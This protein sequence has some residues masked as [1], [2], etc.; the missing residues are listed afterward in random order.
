MVIGTLVDDAGGVFWRGRRKLLILC[1]ICASIPTSRPRIRR[2]T[3]A[4]N[5]M[6]GNRKS[7]SSSNP[8][9][10]PHKP[11]WTA[12]EVRSARRWIYAATPPAINAPGSNSHYRF[13]HQMKP[14]KIRPIPTTTERRLSS[15][16]FIVLSFNGFATF[17]NLVRS[18][19]PVCCIVDIS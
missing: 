4:R 1:W 12:S 8:S 3:P 15:T 6:P 10:T 13:S 17:Y 11:T 16:K 7:T 19:D 18:Y 14:N 2:L 5:R 9:P